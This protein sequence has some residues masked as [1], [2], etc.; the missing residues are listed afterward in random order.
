MFFGNHTDF[1]N[2]L[3]SLS[4]KELKKA[5][6]M[7]E[8]YCQFSP[9]FA[10]ILGL[11]LVNLETND[12]FTSKEKQEIRFMYSG[13]NENKHVEIMKKLIKIGADLK[14][15]DIYGFTPLHYAVIYRNPRMVMFLLEKGA[16]PNSESIDGR[17]PMSNLKRPTTKLDFILIDILVQHKGKLI[18]KEHINE[19]RSYLEAHSNIEFTARMREAM[20]RDKEECEKCGKH[21]EKKCSACSVVYYCTLACQK[22][23]W[24]F[25]KVTCKRNKKDEKV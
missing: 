24:K 13:N 18:D 14:A 23:D 1:L 20:P 15:Y 9:V 16:D 8:G 5:L 6:L 7:R 17:R 2:H 22:Q 4:Q 10:P 12:F 19:L 11:S 3:R 21:A 25:H